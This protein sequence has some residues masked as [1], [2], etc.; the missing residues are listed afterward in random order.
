MRTILQVSLYNSVSRKVKREY[1]SKTGSFDKKEINQNV[2]ERY[3][4]ICK[5]KGL[6]P[7]GS[8]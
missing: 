8:T 6:E 3:E 4:S 2:K 5:S 1:V 7:Y